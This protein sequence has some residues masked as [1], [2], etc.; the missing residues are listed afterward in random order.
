VT[1]TADTL[2]GA[3][4]WLNE[5]TEEPIELASIRVT[6][7]ILEAGRSHSLAEQALANSKWAPDTIIHPNKKEFQPVYADWVWVLTADSEPKADALAKLVTTASRNPEYEVIG[8]LTLETR[9]RMPVDV[10]RCY[11]VTVSG[12]GRPHSLTTP[13]ELQQGQLRTVEALAAPATGM[14]IRAELWNFLEGFNFALPREVWG[15]DFGWR[16]NLTGAKVLIEPDAEIVDDHLVDLA[17][18]KAGGMMLVSAHSRPWGKPLRAISMT[19]W[20]LVSMLGFA[21][22]KDFFR[23]GEE[24]RAWVQWLRS[25]KL[26]RSITASLARLPIRDRERTRKLRAHPF[27]D[28]RRTV[29]LVFSRFAD[30]VASFS[31]KSEADISLDDLTSDDYVTNSANVKRWSTLAIGS[32]VSLIGAFLAARHLFGPGELSGAWLLPAPDSSIEFLGNYLY[33]L[34]GDPT[35]PTPAWAGITALASFITFG[36]PDWLIS[37]VL[38]FGVPLTWLLAYR[39]A[40]TLIPDGLVAAFAA[41]AYALLPVLLGAYNAGGYSVVL[42]AMLLP[43]AG[44]SAWW[45]RGPGLRT[46]RGAGVL[47]LWLL[48]LVALLPLTWVLAFVCLAAFVALRF[49]WRNLLQSVL[50]LVVPG[51][52]LICP[53]FTTL[54]YYPGRLLTGASPMLHTS[55]PEPWL[56]PFLAGNTS[57]G[58]PPQWLSISVLSVL[59]LV[60]FVAAF[61]RLKAGLC[62]VAA[63]LLL[64]VIIAMRLL[65]LEVSP[66]VKVHPDGAELS[67]LMGGLLLAGTAIGMRG[68]LTNLRKLSLGLKHFGVL[69]V[70]IVSLGAVCLASGWW[71]WDG[72]AQLTRAPVG[73][74]PTFLVNAMEDE[75]QVVLAVQVVESEGAYGASHQSTWALL[76]DGYPRLGQEETS[77]YWGG[78][79]ADVAGS[80]VRR[81]LVG[82]QDEEILPELQNLGVAYVWL[83]NGT[84][85]QIHAISN[86]PGFG[87]PT[88]VG[89]S[90]VWPLSDFLGWAE[91]APNSDYTWAYLQLA[92][93]VLLLLLALPQVRARTDVT[94][95][96]RSAGGA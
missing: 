86:T 39:F 52:L 47:A 94:G 29:H 43:L 37:L 49:S 68:F 92:G 24:G 85:T 31:G 78:G 2:D 16:A 64:G 77:A 59:W 56:V 41:A 76:Q 42:Y 44:F 65:E 4:D 28:A 53:W 33:S 26:R 84:A 80:V 19:F 18:E 69:A 82:S 40:R 66:G 46:W 6:A 87:A 23:A 13:G 70:A 48:G 36:N 27:S 7:L 11:G 45:W 74:L 83:Q 25:G 81:L 9:S 32:V 95:P 55:V 38:L 21:L 5:D 90:T 79:N 63:A 73:Q 67:M 8:A 14:L 72:T 93:A 88:T 34:P 62:L 3:W 15:L 50:I 30:W 51:L 10:V 22:G 1:N 35:S 61:R 60:A 71:I 91:L 20:T 17:H 96:R 54:T 89:D 12:S 57:V 58:V 75:G